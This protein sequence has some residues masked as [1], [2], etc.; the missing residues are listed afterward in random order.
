[1]WSEPINELANTSDEKVMLIDTEGLGSLEEDQNHDAKIFALA[2]LISSLLVY[3]SV[4]SIDDEA[5]QRLGLVIKLSKY[6]DL[7]EIQ[8]TPKLLWLLRDFSL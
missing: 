2:L 6:V 1:M 3:N 4:G 7:D 8:Q 5:I